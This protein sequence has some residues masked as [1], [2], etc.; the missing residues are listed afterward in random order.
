MNGQGFIAATRMNRDG[1]RVVIVVRPIITDVSS[2]GCRNR[3]STFRGD[4][5]NSSRNDTP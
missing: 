5:G 1:N 2:S 4:F 3:S